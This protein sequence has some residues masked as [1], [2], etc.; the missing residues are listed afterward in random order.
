M[1]G[2]LDYI[3]RKKCGCYRA[4]IAGD[5]PRERI[6]AAVAEWIRKGYSV[7]RCTTEEARAKLGAC[8]HDR[9]WRPQVH[10]R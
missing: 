10:T 9:R 4:W 8:P 6:A 5:E 7:E 3:A 2:E 1:S